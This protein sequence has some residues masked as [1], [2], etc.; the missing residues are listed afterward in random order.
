MATE[1]D[2][3]DGRTESANT[4][5]RFDRWLDE[6]TSPRRALA[7]YAVLGVFMLFLL[8]PVVYMVLATFTNRSFLYSSALIPSL[9]DLTL[10]NYVNVLSTGAF[11]RYFVNSTIIASATTVLTLT[12][13]TLAGYS[14]SRFEYPGRDSL[15]LAFLGTQMLPYVLIL[16][17]FFLLMFTL[18]LIN[19]HLRIIIAHSVI[20][21]P[22]A[23]WLLK[24]Y[25]DDIPESLDEAAKMDGCS[26][27]DILVRVVLPCRC[28][29]WPS[30]ASTRSPSRGTTSCSCRCCPRP[31]RPGRSRSD[32]SVPVPEPGRLAPRAHGG[33]D[34]HDPGHCPVRGGPA[35]GRQGSRQR[36][37]EG[38]LTTSCPS[39][40][41]LPA[42]R[43]PAGRRVLSTSRR[44]GHSHLD[45]NLTDVD[46]IIEIAIT[47]RDFVARSRNFSQNGHSWPLITVSALITLTGRIRLNFRYS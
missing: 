23:I 25:F 30:L 27:L 12:V 16:I 35:V 8:L 47:K 29:A 6:E 33:D 31:A 21:T 15:L 18:G 14:L 22:L 26:Q 19:S 9:S 46:I 28:R 20:A 39:R 24:G 38:R 44:R 37:H 2:A 42:H 36:R 17:P 40:S 45:D 7:V 4:V 1:T 34:H 43:H 32:C 41:P 5:S 3:V 10:A 11:Q 13:G